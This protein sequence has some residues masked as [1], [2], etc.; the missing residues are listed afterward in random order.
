MTMQGDRP[1]TSIT[2]LLAEGMDLFEEELAGVTKRDWG[3][4]TPCAGWTVEDVV[5]HTADTADRATAILRNELWEASESV[6]SPKYRWMESSSA[7][8]EALSNTMLDDRW[9]LPADSPDGKLMFHGCDFVVHRWDLGVGRGAER[10]LPGGWV[11][12]MDSF[13]HSVSAEVLRRPRAFHEPVQPEPSDGP[14]RRLM[15][16]LGRRV[17]G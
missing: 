4:E 17:Q 3:K 5:R 7:L 14:T 2:R 11:A 12:F 10:E 6:A 15:A 8:R 9:P 1:P 16:F 13:F